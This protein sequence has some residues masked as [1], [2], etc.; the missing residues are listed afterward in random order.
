[1]TVSDSILV[2]SIQPSIVLHDLEAT[3]QEYQNLLENSL[4]E[5]DKRKVIC[6]PE[7]WNG[8]RGKNVNS[9]NLDISIN[10]LKTVS[11][12]FGAFIIGGSIVTL[13][14]KN[15]VNQS[16]VI[17]PNGKIIGKYEK[18]KLFGYEKIQEFAKGSS[19]FFWNISGFRA[20]IRICNDLWNTQLT[21]DLIENEIDVLFVPALTVVPDKSFTLYGRYLWHNLALIRAKECAA[22][23]IV[24][25]SAE[26]PLMQ[27]YWT[28]GSS[29]IVDPSQKFTNIEKAGDNMVINLDLGQRGI[30]RKRIELKDIREQKAYRKEVGLLS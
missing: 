2:I 10:Y 28:T 3:I 19:N 14:E 27:P 4:F 15:L 8:L 11:K 21:Q 18:Q 12:K 26:G 23:V 1:M 17:A 22:A 30:I 29:I 5:K 13:K 24:S 6:F 25:D 9:E 20:S 16:T 7:Y